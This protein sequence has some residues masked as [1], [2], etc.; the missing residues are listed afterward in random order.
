MRWF[1]P[2][3][4][5]MLS[6]SIINWLVSAVDFGSKIFALIIG[7]LTAFY[8]FEKLKGE[9]LNNIEKRRRLKEQDEIN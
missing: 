5:L 8:I 7:I 2:T 9:R 3:Y 1:E 6:I 4:L